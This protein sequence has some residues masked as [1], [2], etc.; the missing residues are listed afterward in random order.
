MNT[1]SNN[2]AQASAEPSESLK[3]PQPIMPKPLQPHFC[4]QR[5]DNT[6]VPLIAIDELPESVILKGVPIKLTVLDAL[7]AHMTLTN[8]EYPAHGVRYQLDRPLDTQ[9]DASEQGYYSASDGSP[10]SDGSASSTQKGRASDKKGNKN[11][12]DKALVRMHSPFGRLHSFSS[13]HT[14]YLYHVETSNSHHQR[15]KYH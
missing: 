2:Q 14:N 11:M 6:V 1:N 9:V 13:I 15:Q 7:K 5:D 4:V 10:T 8:G 12:K 3:T